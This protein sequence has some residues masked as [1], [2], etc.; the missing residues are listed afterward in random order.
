MGVGNYLLI[1]AEVRAS[2]R[3]DTRLGRW[4]TSSRIR[5]TRWRAARKSP[6]DDLSL[7]DPDDLFLGES[8]L[9]HDPSLWLRNQSIAGSGLGGHLTE[10]KSESR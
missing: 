5:R 7:L 9:S 8:A 2:A 4:T 10:M 6:R 3:V 1:D